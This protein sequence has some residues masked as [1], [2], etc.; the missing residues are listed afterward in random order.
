MLAHGPGSCVCPLQKKSCGI[1]GG[2][3]DIRAGISVV[4]MAVVVALVVLA[5]VCMICLAAE[6]NFKLAMAS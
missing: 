1:G 3:P 4:V 5:V 2:S 6:V